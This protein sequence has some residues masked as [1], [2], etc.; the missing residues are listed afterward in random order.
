[1]T[2]RA[3]PFLKDLVDDI[4]QSNPIW[5]NCQGSIAKNLIS[6]TE[7]ENLRRLPTIW[8]RCRLQPT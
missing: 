6:V 3:V 7:I 2:I 4:I 5:H 1:M 8:V